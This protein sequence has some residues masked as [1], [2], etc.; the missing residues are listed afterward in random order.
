MGPGQCRCCLVPS[1]L[2]VQPCHTRLLP[3]W[4]PA[5]ELLPHFVTVANGAV[6]VPTVQVC[7]CMH[8]WGLRMGG[9]RSAAVQGANC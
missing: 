2:A 1:L 8:C 5:D 7:G 4:I 9:R 3:G 6:D